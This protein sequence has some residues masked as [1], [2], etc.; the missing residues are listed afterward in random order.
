MVAVFN[1]QRGAVTVNVSAGVGG[2]RSH[3][4]TIVFLK[5]GIARTTISMQRI[6]STFIAVCYKINNKKLLVNSSKIIIIMFF[7]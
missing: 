6:L 2:V 4:L 3:A 7:S 1:C 5:I